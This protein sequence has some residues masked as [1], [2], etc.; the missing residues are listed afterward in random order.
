MAFCR[1]PSRIHCTSDAYQGHAHAPVTF[2]AG[3]AG[4]KVLVNACCCALDGASTL[5]CTHAIVV[6][7]AHGAAHCMHSNTAACNASGCFNWF[8]GAYC[9]FNGRGAPGMGALRP[10]SPHHLHAREAALQRTACTWYFGQSHF[11]REGF[12]WPGPSLTLQL[13]AATNTTRSCSTFHSAL[14]RPGDCP[15]LARDN[16]AH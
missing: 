1:S 8:W 11:F 6:S 5:H 3:S 13:F 15:L 16:T 12:Q 9:F 14:R 7:M 4:C 10:Q 2:S